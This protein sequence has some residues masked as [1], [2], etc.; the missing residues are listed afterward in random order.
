MQRSINAICNAS[1][2]N[3]SSPKSGRTQSGQTGRNSLFRAG[4]ESIFFK[5]WLNT[6]DRCENDHETLPPMATVSVVLCLSCASGR[7]LILLG[8]KRVL[9]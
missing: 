2:L 5:E 9:E 7:W 3:H 6:A 1:R 8:G 4:F